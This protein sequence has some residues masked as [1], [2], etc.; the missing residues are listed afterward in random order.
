MAETD[1]APHRERKWTERTISPSPNMGFGGSLKL[2]DNQFGADKRNCFW[3]EYFHGG[4]P[5][6]EHR[7]L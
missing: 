7:Q 4:G 2:T 6:T 5:G 3:A 1:E